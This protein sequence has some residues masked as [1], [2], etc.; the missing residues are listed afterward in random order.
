MDMA[1][2]NLMVMTGLAFAAVCFCRAVSSA[3]KAGSHPGV[4]RGIVT[5]A[6]TGEA[7]AN[8]YVGVGEFGD[9]G[10]SNRS[11]HREEGLFA[12]GQTD[13]G[14]KFEL[15]GLVLTE[16]HKYLKSHP[17]VVTHNDYVR[18]DM[19]I[20]LSTDHIEADV[21]VTLHKAARIDVTVVDSKGG[22]IEGHWI[23]RLEDLSG[24]RFIPPGQDPHMSTFSSSVWTK[25][26]DLRAGE[27]MG[28]SSGFSFH[29]LGAGE[30]CVEAIR[31]DMLPNPSPAAIW[32]Q[33]WIYHGQVPRIRIKAG[34]LKAVLIAPQDNGT[35]LTISTPAE[36]LRGLS[37]QEDR[38]KDALEGLQIRGI[39]KISRNPRARAWDM[40]RVYHVEDDRLGR[41]QRESMLFTMASPGESFTIENLTPGQYAVF[42]MVNVKVVIAMSSVTIEVVSGKN[43]DV[44]MPV[45]VIEGRGE[46]EVR[47]LDRRLE[48]VDREYTVKELC[49]I[50]S[51]ATESSP[52]LVAD[53]A[54]ENDVVRI[55]GG[56]IV[57][58]DLVERLCAQK[59]LKLK[60]VG[61]KKLR[62]GN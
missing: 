18:A 9:S 32:K 13:S 11:R 49:R 15:D 30:Y 24:K 62:I 2:R 10:G 17:L 23:L 29:A 40:G 44:E 34:E 51:D 16:G 36:P 41:I 47:A 60:E 48:L 28:R 14:G 57:M 39:L 54:I 12:K 33:P 22:P 53:P 45:P 58:W 31:L 50:V 61:R 59:R 8:A 42:S 25:H 5:D 38:S 7:V 35:R 4:I 46:V 19:N 55:G 26:P 43:T 3:E 21:T 27:T 52:E 20:E 6:E 1:K 56:E 37:K